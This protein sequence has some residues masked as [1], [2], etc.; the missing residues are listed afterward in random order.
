MKQRSRGSETGIT[1]LLEWGIFDDESYLDEVN[2]TY[3]V[4][5]LK[6]LDHG[7]I[8]TIEGVDKKKNWKEGDFR[9]LHDRLSRLISPFDEIGGFKIQLEIPSFPQFTGVVEPHALTRM[10]KYQLLGSLSVEG[11][12]HRQTEGRQ[13]SPQE[14]RNASDRR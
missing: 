9:N 8:L 14:V 6:E 7:T 11:S 2:I 3:E 1:V 10:P 4:T 13:Q 5:S 12:R